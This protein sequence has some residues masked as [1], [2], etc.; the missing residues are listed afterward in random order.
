MVSKSV[1]MLLDDFT[2]MCREIFDGSLTGVYLHGSM[3]MGCFNPEKSDIDLIVVVSGSISKDR[4]LD[5]MQRLV[6]LNENA[7]RKGLDCYRFNA[8]MDLEHDTAQK[9]AEYMQREIQKYSF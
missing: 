5:F 1:E 9:F 3:A 4:K 6:R 7:P 8:V 2:A